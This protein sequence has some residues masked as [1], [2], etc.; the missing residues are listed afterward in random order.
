MYQP[1]VH[2]EILSEMTSLPYKIHFVG[3]ES[4]R[5]QTAIGCPPVV[6]RVPLHFAHCIWGTPGG[7]RA[8]IASIADTRGC[9]GQHGFPCRSVYISGAAGIFAHIIS[10]G[11]LG[12]DLFL[13]SCLAASKSFIHWMPV[14]PMS[15][16]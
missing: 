13:V 4:T 10:S 8:S 1:F 2:A 5:L 11:C 12:S 6:R 15:P 14:V 3:N 7:V 16:L 9:V